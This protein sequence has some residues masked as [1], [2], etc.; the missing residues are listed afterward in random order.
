MRS[1]DNSERASPIRLSEIEVA[2]FDYVALGHHHAAME[3]VT[4]TATAA[5]SGSPTDDVG[6]GPT[7][8]TVDLVDGLR[9]ALTIDRVA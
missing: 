8:A 7:F 6:R 4:R 2:D 5:Y 3:I 1:V 9:P